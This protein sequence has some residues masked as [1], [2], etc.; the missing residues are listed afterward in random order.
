[1]SA[2]RPR[3]TYSMPSGAP[4][5]KARQHGIATILI[6]LLVGMSLSAA[7]LGVM[8]Y[9]RAAQNQL[10]SVHTQTQAQMRAWTGAEAVRLYL[11]EMQTNKQLATLAA[12][13]GTATPITITGLTG[14]SAKFVAVDST[15]APTKFTAEIT[16]TGAEGNDAQ[17]KSTL[18][19]LYAVTTAT[20]P[21][22]TS[23][24]NP[25]VITFKRNLRLGGG[26]E[27]EAD[28]SLGPVTINVDGDVSTSGNSITGVKILN[29]TGSISIGSGSAF[30]QLNANCDVQ[31]TGSVN[32][33]I[34]NARRNVCFDG[35][36]WG[37]EAI[38]ANGSVKA[39]AAYEKNG[40]IS[41]IGNP[42]GVDSC[43][44]SGSSEDSTNSL[45]ATC[46]VP[47]VEVDLSSGSAGAK[48]VKTKGS[49]T[50][51]S[52]RIGTLEAEGGLTVNWGSVV[53]SGV[54]GGKITYPDPVNFDKTKVNVVGKPGTTVLIPAVSLLTIDS[55]VINARDYRDAANYVF[56]VDANGYKKVKVSSV[57]GIADG[58]YF[59]ARFV[60]QN[61]D[62]VDYLCS[63]L[64]ASSTADSP[65][66]DAALLNSAKTICEG[67]S[68]QNTCF[69]YDKNKRL[70]SING[71]SMAPGVAWFEGSLNVGSGT[72][73]NSF[74]VTEN[75]TTSGSDVI[76][77]PNFA[78]FNGT[79]DGKKYAP[80]GICKNS[81][82]PDLYPKQFCDMTNQKYLQDALSGLGNFVFIAGSFTGTYDKSTYLG[83]NIST[84]A[85]T[86]LFGSVKAGN[87]FTSAGDTTIHGYITALALGMKVNNAMT[88]RT[89]IKL[90]GL[91]PTYSP[92]GGNSTSGGGAPGT[93]GGGTSGISI[94]WSRYL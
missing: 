80:T 70:W 81:S 84:G 63:K 52:G 39:V 25:N 23:P 61:N 82:F 56:T 51:A 44:A 94:L 21:S 36:A 79:A 18:Q 33:R 85:S 22:S 92:S 91:P 77:A 19:V 2:C 43:R 72:Y 34:V 29:S 67:F 68:A 78:G 90:K 1:M 53:D 20:E 50:L 4:T 89:T 75:V 55:Y 26:I 11:A 28:E 37:S 83:G 93:G 74:V 6:V 32:S 59:I 17:S 60:T 48:S 86:E 45:A 46:A 35:G 15:T 31:L 16:G 10:L 73:Y 54:V 76:Y 49:V 47:T 65:V 12:K 9:I 13:I 57:N 41:A 40:A 62:K 14:V 88:A 8:Y 87:E 64:D 58:D 5:L 66:C 7:V 24:P 69:N 30:D 27:V 42:T 3:N 38:N 71:K